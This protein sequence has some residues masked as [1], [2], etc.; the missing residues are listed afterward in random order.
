MPAGTATSFS[1]CR[2]KLNPPLQFSFKTHN[3]TLYAE[4][5]Y[6]YFLMNPVPAAY[7]LLQEWKCATCAADVQGGNHRGS[8][9]GRISLDQ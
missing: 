1:V 6:E 9:S 7:P 8:L 5:L 3:V 4:C 2:A